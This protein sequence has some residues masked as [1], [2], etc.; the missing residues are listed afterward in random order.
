MVSSSFAIIRR[1]T[2][3]LWFT[4]L[5]WSWKER[6]SIVPS[7]KEDLGGILVSC[8]TIQMVH[9]ENKRTPESDY[10]NDLY[11]QLLASDRWCNGSASRFLE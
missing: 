1:M 6:H 9:D 7:T 8:N 11:Y 10:Q 2:V 5:L 4:L 3:H